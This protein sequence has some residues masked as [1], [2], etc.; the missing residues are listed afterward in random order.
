MS[1]ENEAD[2][3]RTQ[4]EDTRASLTEKLETLE[5]QIVETVQGATSAVTDTVASVKD[6]VTDTVSEVK[7]TVSETVDTVKSTFDIEQ[8]VQKHPWLVFAGAIAAGFVAERLLN[9]VLEPRQGAIPPSLPT[10]PMPVTQP[11]LQ[12]IYGGNGHSHAGNGHLRTEA[13]SDPTR[14]HNRVTL[15][16]QTEASGLTDLFGKEIEQLKKV[17]IGTTMD[18]V[19]DLVTDAIPAPVREDLRQILDSVTTKLGG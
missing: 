16:A 8:Q 2:A 19:R 7:A 9:R 14:P 12:P 6:A 17:A 11:D 1:M 3:I 13:V 4:M 5:Q 18:L 10:P 15:P